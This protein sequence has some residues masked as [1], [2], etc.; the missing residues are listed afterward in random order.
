MRPR[1]FLFALFALSFAAVAFVFGCSDTDPNYGPT[2]AIHRYNPDLGG[3]TQAPPKEGGT[4]TQDVKTLFQAVYDAT[5]NCAGCHKAGGV[6]ASNPKNIFYGANVDETYTIFKKP[7][8][9]FEKAG[10]KFY[11]IGQHTGPPISAQQ[12]ATMDPWIAAEAA[13]GGTSTPTDAGGG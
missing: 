10:S 9:G 11:T 13:G 4:G 8:N 6:A 1:R 7:E 3:T 12:K 5:Q 2:G